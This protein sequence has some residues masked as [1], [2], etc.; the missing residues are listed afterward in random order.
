MEI[1]TA[2]II[3]CA[4]LDARVSPPATNRWVDAHR[5]SDTPVY[6]IVRISA[7]F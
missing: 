4:T 3:A 6:V 5:L 2:F 7:N 1:L